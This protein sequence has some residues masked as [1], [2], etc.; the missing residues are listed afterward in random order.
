MYL[1][2]KKKVVFRLH[3]KFLC[4]VLYLWVGDLALRPNV[5]GGHEVF[6]QLRRSFLHPLSVSNLFLSF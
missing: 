4:L 2:M 6:H 3:T 1:Y 5:V